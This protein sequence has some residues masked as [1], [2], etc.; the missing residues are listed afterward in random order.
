MP[1]HRRP[2]ARRPVRTAP[3]RAW[4]STSTDP[5]PLEFNLLTGQTD[6]GELYI[7]NVGTTSTLD[8]RIPLPTVSGPVVIAQQPL[9]L[10]K[11]EA[12]PR[13]GDPVVDG[14]GGPDLFGYRWMDSDEPGGPTF[15]WN[16]ISLTGTTIAGLDGDDETSAA[17]ALG[18][19]FSF[20]GNAFDS[21][22][23]CTNGW[24]SFTSTATTYSNQT[25][26]TTS[27]PENMLAPF[28]DDLDFNGAEK[29]A[30]YGDGNSF[31]VQYTNVEHYPSGSSYT[32][33]VEI[34]AS[35]APSASRTPRKTMA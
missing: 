12:D 20:Y 27:G 9:A 16:D 11:D 34:F 21:V 33:Q 17:I 10:E 7:D 30:Y 25:L 24:I 28:W 1:R 26:P 31:I 4:R 18:F 22:R 23:V 6:T 19:D 32:F 5:D 15:A 35:G 13:V 29:A 3:R 2:E 8:W 14:F